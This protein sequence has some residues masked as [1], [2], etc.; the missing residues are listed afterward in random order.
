MP[1]KKRFGFIDNH[2]LGEANGTNDIGELTNSFL[3]CVC[4]FR[5]FGLIASTQI[6]SISCMSTSMAA[7]PRGMQRRRLRPFKF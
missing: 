1:S 2:R 6:S 5:G 4:A 3:G 7:Q